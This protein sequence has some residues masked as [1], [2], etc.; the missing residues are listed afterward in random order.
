MD[1]TKNYISVYEAYLKR[2]MDMEKIKT[3]EKKIVAATGFVFVLL[4]MT[5]PVL[6]DSPIYDTT[7]EYAITISVMNDGTANTST[8]QLSVTPPIFHGRSDVLSIVS[9]TC[10]VVLHK[11]PHFFT[12]RHIFSRIV[13]FS[14]KHVFIAMMV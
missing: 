3:T 8:Q 5:I 14:H 10:D 4:S 13:T 7:K 2:G 6:W 9:R 1:F 11:V 12:Y